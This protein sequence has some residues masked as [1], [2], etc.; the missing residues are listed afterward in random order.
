M[1]FGSTNPKVASGADNHDQS[2][3]ALS[4]DLSEELYPNRFVPSDKER[5]KDFWAYTRFAKDKEGVEGVE[6]AAAPVQKRGSE[7]VKEVAQRKKAFTLASK[8]Y[9]TL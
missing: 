4:Y 2:H 3:R 6:A 1:C 5:E 7:G 8:T 9:S